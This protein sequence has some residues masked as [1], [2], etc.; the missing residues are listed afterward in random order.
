M[1]RHGIIFIGQLE[2][3]EGYM[4]DQQGQAIFTSGF[5]GYVSYD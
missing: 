1:G 5:E 3:F 4:I 2:G